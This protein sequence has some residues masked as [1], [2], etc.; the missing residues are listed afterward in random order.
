MSM[1]ER[2]A[3]HAKMRKVML[4]VFKENEAAV[5]FYDKM[6]YAV[7]L[8]SPSQYGQREET[9]RDVDYEILSKC[10]GPWKR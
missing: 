6:A 1:L 10:V 5:R 3:E 9:E 4:T 2:I 8:I 7:D